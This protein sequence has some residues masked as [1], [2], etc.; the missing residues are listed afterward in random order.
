M[1]AS[2]FL[3]WIFGLS[4]RRASDSF[5]FGLF[6]AVAALTAADETLAVVDLAHGPLALATSVFLLVFVFRADR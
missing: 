5:C 4:S 2:D 3:K 1:G 6:G